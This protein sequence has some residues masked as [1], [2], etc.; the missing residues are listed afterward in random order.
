M[1][2]DVVEPVCQ[3]HRR[4]AKLDLTS[5]N[6]LVHFIPIRQLKYFGSDALEPQTAAERHDVLRQRYAHAGDY[7]SSLAGLPCISQW[8]RPLQDLKLATCIYMCY[9]R[10]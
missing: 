2:L 7:G 3:N 4:E 9:L 8:I 5:R 10:Q 6:E 1:G